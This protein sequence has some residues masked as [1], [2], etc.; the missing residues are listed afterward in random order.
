M[1]APGKG[2]M[3]MNTIELVGTLKSK[4]QWMKFSKKLEKAMGDYPLDGVT[5]VVRELTAEELNAD[6]DRQVLNFVDKSQCFEFAV[7]PNERPPAAW[8]IAD[9][10]DYFLNPDED[11]ARISRRVLR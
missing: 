6:H 3:S 10:I 9:R 7:A 4:E 5:V 8:T 2:W 1:I 11:A